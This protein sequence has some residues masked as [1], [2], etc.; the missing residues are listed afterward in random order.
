MA[1]S[2]KC[3]TRASKMPRWNKN[4]HKSTL[5]R[6]ERMYEAN[7]LRPWSMRRSLPCPDCRDNDLGREQMAP[8]PGV[9]ARLEPT[10]K[11]RIAFGCETCSGTGLVRAEGKDR[12]D[13]YMTLKAMHG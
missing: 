12:L 13:P 2:S 3:H 4:G 10:Y 1:A 9:V 11:T 7:E 8:E 5:S 6:D